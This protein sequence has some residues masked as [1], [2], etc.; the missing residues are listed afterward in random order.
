MTIKLEY[1]TRDFDAYFSLLKTEATN[2][3]PEWTDFNDS[4][5]GVLFLELISAL[6]DQNSFYINQGLNEGF[7]PTVVR[8]KNGIKVLNRMAYQLD[9][10]TAASVDLTFTFEGGGTHA[11]DVTIP[12]G[13]LVKTE[14]SVYNFET[15]IELIILAGNANGI[16]SAR[17]NLTVT[18][19]LSF[20][21]TVNQ[22]KKLKQTTFTEAVE[23]SIASLIW[24]EQDDLID[25]SPTDKHFTVFADEFG[26]ATL[27]FGDGV[28]GALPNG[29]GSC[30]YRIGG[31]EDA[32]SI[33]P[34]TITKLG[35]PILD[36]LAVEVDMEV[37]NVSSPSGGEEEESLDEARVK[38]PKEMKVAETT[39]SRDDYEGHSELVPGVARALAHGKQQ[40]ASIPTGV[41]WVYIVPEGG[42]APSVQ[43]L[44][45]VEDFLINDKPI[46]SG[47][48]ISA[49]NPTY[50]T[51][52]PVAQIFPKSGF[53]PADC[54]TAAKAAITQYFEFDNLDDLNK[55]TADFGEY[56]PKF[57]IS[58]L[59]DIILNTKIGDLKCIENTTVTSPASDVTIPTINMSELGSLA[60]VTL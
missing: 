5:V 37:T 25:S 38:A 40:N 10:L 29:S 35:L 56:K 24:T 47:S 14:D 2:Q 36:A 31:G 21:N 51:I 15:T 52:T 28:N 53:V 34:D 43:L 26:V 46:M 59:I 22:T 23:V 30:T 45:D 39:V 58:E 13:Y 12:A 20:D 42:G 7:L 3:F 44:S 50:T 9:L 57:F 6:G 8:K 60:G 16:V 32:N 41:M 55:H 4:N 19:S 27:S 18:D 33:Q 17:N 49:A 54:L 48:G 1:T 11:E